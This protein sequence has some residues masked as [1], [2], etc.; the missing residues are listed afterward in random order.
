MKFVLL[1]IIFF[2]WQDAS[3]QIK[4]FEQQKKDARGFEVPCE[5]KNLNTDSIYVFKNKING[6][7]V[8]N[9]DTT[10]TYYSNCFNNRY[11][12]I[13]QLKSS[14]A[15]NKYIASTFL[16][17]ITNAVIFDCEN[18][19]FVYFY[20][21]SSNTMVNQIVCFKKTNRRFILF[22]KNNQ[23]I[24]FKRYKQTAPQ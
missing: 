16:V 23:K 7:V 20:P 10:C 21:G 6:T 3:A 19:D 1:A 18:P 8:Y 22:T 12:M 15:Y 2:A 14:I 13:K 24:I 11:Y 5:F 4:I 17:P 9:A